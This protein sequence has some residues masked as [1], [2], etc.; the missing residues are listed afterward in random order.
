MAGNPIE[1]K[2]FPLGIDNLHR[3]DSLPFGALREAI[4]IDLDYQGKPSRRR[5]KQRVLEGEVHSITALPQG[6][7]A[8]VVDGDLNVYSIDDP[9]APALVTTV[10][11]DIGDRTLSWGHTPH[12]SFWT[13]G[14]SLRML[15]AAFQDDEAWPRVPGWPATADPMSAGGLAAGDYQVV[16]TSVDNAGRESGAGRAF[17]VSSVPEGGGILLSGLPDPPEARF[18]AVYVTAANDDVLHLVAMATPGDAYMITGGDR[19][20]VLEPQQQWLEPMPAG[21]ALCVCMGRLF[22]AQGR[23]LYFSEPTRYGAM[24][25]DNRITF[26][27]NI[28]LL[29]PTGSGPEAG[30]YVAAGRRTMYLAGGNPKEAPLTVARAVGAVPGTSILVHTSAFSSA[31]KD[32]PPN[33]ASVWISA[34]GVY[35]LGLPGGSILPLTEKRL[36]LPLNATDGA[37]MLRTD[38]GLSQIVTSLSGGDTNTA[39]ATDKLVGTIYRGGIST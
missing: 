10:V 22:V 39:G 33:Q 30:L 29:A 15:T 25:P 20:R 8:A 9:T 5:G 12:R 2:G 1:Y 28:S 38:D 3:E 26:G 16:L 4:N 19:G 31:F 24:L 13:D 21:Q 32:L 18:L 35:C 14:A 27:E 6:G 36:V 23:T 34:D 7:L 11:A 17:L 37:T